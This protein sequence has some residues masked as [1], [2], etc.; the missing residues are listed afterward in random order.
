[1]YLSQ[2][3]KRIIFL[4]TQWTKGRPGRPPLFVAG[5]GD[6]RDE[7]WSW[8]RRL[9]LPLSKARR[10]LQTPLIP[11]PFAGALL[12]RV[13]SPVPDASVRPCPREVACTLGDFEYVFFLSQHPRLGDFSHCKLS[14]F[15]FPGFWVSPRRPSKLYLTK[16][17]RSGFFQT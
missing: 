11:V 15:N 9:D 14:S 8:E 17:Q 1:M 16:F 13:A 5:E 4:G 2:L 7:G 10:S 12:I 6:Q 3:A